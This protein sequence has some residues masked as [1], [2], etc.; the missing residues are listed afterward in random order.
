M[1]NKET[2]IKLD[3]EHPFILKPNVAKWYER[4]ERELVV[5]ASPS[6]IEGYVCFSLYMMVGPDRVHRYSLVMAPGDLPYQVIGDGSKKA[7][8]ERYLRKEAAQNLGIV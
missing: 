1:I 5:V 4:R 8:E 3:P 6:L 2:L 7:L